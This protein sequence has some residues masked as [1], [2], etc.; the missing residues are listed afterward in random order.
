MDGT[1]ADD[2]LLDSSNDA[3]SSLNGNWSRGEDRMAGGT[4]DDTYFVNSAGDQVI[5]K[6]GEGNDTV[7]SRLAGITLAEHVEALRLDGQPTERIEFPDGSVDYRPAA[8]D[9][10]GNRLDN[11]MYGNTNDNTLWG[12]DG[13]DTLFGGDGNDVLLGGNGDDFLMGGFDGD[14]Y[15]ENDTLVGGNG[16][17]RLFGR[18][19]DDV[20]LGGDG[21]DRLDG[22]G[23]N[24]RLEGGRGNDL[25]LVDGMNDT[26]VESGWLGGNDTVVSIHSYTLGRN[27]ENLKLSEE[28]L[29]AADATGNELDNIITGNQRINKLSGLGGNDTLL[30]NGG[31]DTLDGGDG[32]DTLIGQYGRSTLIGGQGQDRF[33]FTSAGAPDADTIVDFSHADDAFVLLDALDARLPGGV[34]KGIQG[35]TFEDG[36]AEGHALLDRWFFKGDGQTGAAAGQLSGIYVNTVDGQV[37]YNPTSAEGGDALLLGQVSLAAAATLDASDFLYGA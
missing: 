35:L 30:A 33:V 15:G 25:Y 14:M 4:G 16:H 21:N 13:N 2:D 11:T 19:G 18:N 23:G 22:G 17:D 32:D 9:G 12:M 27:V 36:T 26:V 7:V 1:D 3:S 10:I 29:V 20:L 24:D 8:L 37:W 31:S 28:H 34:I 5:E 6:A